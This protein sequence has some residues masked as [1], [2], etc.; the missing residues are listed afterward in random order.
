MQPKPGTFEYIEAKI[1]KDATGTS[2]GRDFERLCKWYLENAAIY[3]GLFRKVW[4]WKEWPDRWG[5]DC[6]IDL[7]AEARDGELWAVQCKAVA[8]D[9]SITKAEVDSF[10]S[11]SNRR[12]IAYRLLIASTD[13]IGHNALRTIENQARRASVVR[14]GDLL[15][16]G[17]EWPTE[18]GGKSPKPARWK[19]RPHQRAAIRD[20]LSGF[21][22]HTRGRL[23]M[24]C[25]T[26][27]TLTGLWINE[28]L[29]CRRTILLVPSISLV[30][31]NLKEWGRHAREDFD[32][33]V[34]CSDETVA[35]DRDDPAMRYVADLGIKP[36]TDPKEIAAFLA[37]RR[38]RRALVISTYQSC[39]RVAKGQAKVKKTFDL[40]IC[41]EA[42]RLVGHVESKFAT[43]LDDRRI[44]ARRRLFMTATPRYFTQKAKQRGAEQE[45]ELASM[46]DVAQFGPE[47]HVLSF[48][49]AIT[50]DPPLLTDYQVVVIG[51]TNAEAR[52]WATE[53]RLVRTKDGLETDA[54]TLAAQIGLAKAIKQYDLRRMITFHR[55]IRRASRFVEEARR[56]SLP[57]VIEKMHSSSRPSGRLWARHVS[58]E[59]AASKR[60]SLLKELGELPEGHRGLI[61][62]CSCLGEGVDVPALDGVAFIDPKGS[63]VD[64]IQAVGR[65]IR[66]SPDKTVGTIVIPVFVD[67]SEDADRALEHSAFDP[68]WQVL[69]ALRAHDRRLADELDQ[70]RA[71]LGKDKG[72]K[73]RI[74]LPSNIVLTVPRLLLND[75]EQAFYVRAVSATSDRLPLTIEEVLSRADEFKRRT[76]KWPKAGLQKTAADKD[77]W[78]HIDVC[79]AKG[80]RGLPGGTTLARLLYTHRGVRH[81]LFRP[82]FTVEQILSWAD[83]YHAAHGEWPY[84]HSGLIDGTAEKWSAVNSA[85]NAGRRSLPGGSSLARLLHEERG[86]DNHLTLASLSKS[87]ILRW[88]DDYYAKYRRWPKIRSGKVDGTDETWSGLNAAL[89]TGA[90]GLRGGSSLSRLLARTRGHRSHLD[91]QALSIK[92]ILEWADVYR[93]KHGSWPNTYSG[94]IPGTRDTWRKIDGAL[95]GSLRGLTCR[96]SLAALLAKKRKARTKLSLPRLTHDQILA[97]ADAYIAQHDKWPTAKSGP[98]DGTGESW[99]GVS[100][101]M[102]VGMRG[103]SRGITLAELL[104]QHRG[105]RNLAWR[106]KLTEELILGWA[107]KFHDRNGHWPTVSS[108]RIDGTDE[109]WT[110]VSVAM[111]NGKRGLSGNV[112]LTDLLAIHRGHRN[113][114]KLCQLSE[115]QILT[116]ADEYHSR[117]RRWPSSRSGSIPGTQETWALVND[118]LTRGSRGLTG[119]T[120]LAQLL[121]TRRGVRSVRYLPPLTEKQVLDWIARHERL[122]GELPSAKSKWVLNEPE[123]WF[124]LSQSLRLGL[125]GLTGGSSLAKL[126]RR[127]YRSSASQS[128]ATY[129]R[130]SRGR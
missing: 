75:F 57:A 78:G 50:A 64:I 83:A 1:R 5:R 31:Q 118:A 48:H 34:V 130:P 128:A 101:A 7:I 96:T 40:A 86:V 39:N 53:A 111:R 100:A 11:E 8:P 113:L 91:A 112:T 73:G 125:R 51:V 46:D 9:H 121:V 98:I 124:N 114:R 94:P 24:A 76:G 38:S 105:N 13:G 18:I 95:K 117:N 32:F 15:T 127:H 35:S 110:G 41:D 45:I 58:G 93:S 123:S 25:G 126:R 54:R 89:A 21:K 4:R 115:D 120:T 55:S 108:G 62:N 6:G 17:L 82:P 37:K 70:L 74:K 42:H 43:A 84:A 61:S 87:Q 80:F 79:L 85:L 14:R 119:K 97:W 66:L 71:S 3:R 65:V 129:G 67:E 107:D 33:L 103:L 16:A 99:S 109:T 77:S 23:V 81:H 36:T 106:P 12:Q 30:Q 49:D 92:R 20:V 44:R 104:R 2:F 60:A 52:A 63:I 47:F 28:A 59:T 27:K 122:T 68:V 88:A 22:D 29:G 116:W 102:R 10:L 90:R 69:K 72:R 56:D 26:G 19:P